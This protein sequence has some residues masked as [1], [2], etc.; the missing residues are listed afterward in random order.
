[1]GHELRNPLGVITN[2]MYVIEQCSPD[3]PPLV[4]EYINLVRGQIAISERIVGDLL[5][6][7]RV[8]TPEARAVDLRELVEEQKR[9]LE[10]TTSVTVDAR[11]PDD[12]PPVRMDPVQL[13][14]ILFNLMTNAAQAMGDGGSLTIA[15][16]ADGSDQ[17]VKLSVSDTGPGIPPD[18]L[19]RIFEPLFTT[20]ARGLGLGLWV[21]QNLASANGSTLAA[22]SRPGEGATFTLDMPAAVDASTTAS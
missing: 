21:S 16:A 18:T 3:G 20:K 11:I 22:V 4:H 12:L 8:R 6:T 13:S 2:A 7:A 1:V 15:A 17:R 14:Q 5:D 10:P 9:R 19:D